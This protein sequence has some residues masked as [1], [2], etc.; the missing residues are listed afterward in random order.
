MTRQG[1]VPVP[2]RWTASPPE[3]FDPGALGLNGAWTLLLAARRLGVRTGGATAGWSLDLD[4]RIRRRSAHPTADRMDD[5]IA[6][7]P[8]PLLTGEGDGWRPAPALEAV[9]AAVRDFLAPY[10]PALAPLTD[11]SGRFVVAHLGQSVDGCIASASGHAIH[12]TGDE[13]RAHL[14]RL[15]A[16]CDAVLLGA[17][18]V[19]ADDPRLTVRLVEG[20]SPTRVVLDPDRRLAAPRRVFDD[21][22]APTVVASLPGLA[23]ALDDAGNGVGRAARLDVPADPTGGFDL[24]ALLDALAARGLRRAFVE[25]GGVTVTRFVEAGLVDRLHVAIAPVLIGRGVPGLRLAPA[26]TMR[27]ARRPPARL[28]RMGEDVLWDFDLTL[29]TQRGAPEDGPPEGGSASTS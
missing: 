27:D 12:V 5:D 7:A 29:G 3:G 16:L 25:G 22:A 14:H 8:L 17:S 21:G 9:P 10:L 20:D 13:N 6:G 23:S 24:A 26:E 1:A 15:R 19:A 28:H 2:G 18:S 4:G 11:P